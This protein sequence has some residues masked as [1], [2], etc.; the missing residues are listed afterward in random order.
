MRA[1]ILKEFSELVQT[2]PLGIFATAM[3]HRTGSVAVVWS[4]I[5][6]NIYLEENIPFTI[7]VRTAIKDLDLKHGC[8]LLSWVGIKK[9]R[10]KLLVEPET[11]YK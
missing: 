9:A 4:S 1:M 8:H 5:I 10:P 7:T 6:I 3:A 2:D 11:G